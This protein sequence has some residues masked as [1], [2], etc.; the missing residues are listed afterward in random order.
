MTETFQKKE[1]LY[2]RLIWVV[3]IV[4]P[5]LVAIL[6]NPRLEVR[7]DLG[8]S[9][10]ILPAINA[11]INSVV[12]VLLVLGLVFIKRKQIRYHRLSM[13]G[14]FGLSAIFLVLYV[15]YHLSVGHTPYCGEGGVK[16]LYFIL[17][18]SHIGLSSIIVPLACFSIFRAL[19][20]RYDKHRK[21]AK[22]TWP[23]WTYV[24]I[25]GVVVYFMISPCYP[26]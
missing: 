7:L 8:F 13:L 16:T 5:V 19:S 12:S 2:T 23:I 11:G 25:T 24:A 15:L 20:E 18:F 3:S 1:P 9:P 10:Y 14:A 6:L 26:A 21:I 17:L 4:V 22:I